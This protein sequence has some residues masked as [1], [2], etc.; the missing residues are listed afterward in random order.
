[1]AMT[2][3][4]RARLLLHTLPEA[5]SG[6]GGHSAAY[7]AAAVLVH[8]FGFSPEEAYP[9]MQEYNARCAPAWREHEL[10]HKLRSALSIAGGKPRGY[11][12][13]GNNAERGSMPEY[14]APKRKVAVEYD[15][16]ALKRLVR[17][18]WKIDKEW[19]RS[20][21]PIDP[22]TC[23]PGAV[24]DAL[25]SPEDFI[26]VFGAMKSPGDFMR[27]RGGWFELGRVPDEKSRRISRF[28]EGTREGMIFLIQPVDGKWH[29]VAGEK[30][31]SRRKSKSVV[32]YPKLLLE[33]DKAPPWEWLNA[34]CQQRLPIA[35]ISQSGGRSIHVLLHIGADTKDEWLGCV[36]QVRDT[37][38]KMGCDSQALGNPLVNMRLGNVFREGK[39]KGGQF[40]PFGHG[41]QLQR[42]LY[43]HPRPE[44]VPI[45][46]M[47]VVR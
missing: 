12:V 10:W 37:M 34:M 47:P 30:R 4:E 40:E 38:A 31:M 43:L 15:A 23:E 6:Q 46:A 18:D 42:L 8:G 39:M 3:V 2:L 19:L 28:P 21:S 41:T 33:S 17:P 5:I 29:P 36:E 16:E 13:S 14:V 27:W 20:R 32:S 44:L 24:I 1:M 25:Y 22:K 45:G 35:A 11:L 9:L 7:R 26:M